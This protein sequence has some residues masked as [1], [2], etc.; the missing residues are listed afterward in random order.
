MNSQSERAMNPT[1]QAIRNEVIDKR[2]KQSVRWA[3][4][5]SLDDEI[6]GQQTK[7]YTLTIEQGTDFYMEYLT[8]RCFSYD[9]SNAT[10]FPIPNSA[11]STAWAGRGLTMQI[12]DSGSG[13]PLT[14]GFV[15]IET[16]LTPGYGQNFQQPYPFRYYWYA[17][18]KIRFDIRNVDNSNRTHKFSIALKGYKYL[19]Q[20][21]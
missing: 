4:T 11:G 16:I 20:V 17:N 8:G 14:S 2:E 5:Y 9:A 18:S 12:T 1:F 6:A 15:P 3:Y 19:S 13:R 21:A 10:D 7:P